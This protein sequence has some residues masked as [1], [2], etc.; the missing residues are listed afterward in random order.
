MLLRLT[1]NNIAS[2]FN[3]A[4]DI[5]VKTSTRGQGQGLASSPRPEPSRPWTDLSRPR[6]DLEAKDKFC[7]RGQGLALRTTSLVDRHLYNYIPGC[8]LDSIEY[9]Q[10][11]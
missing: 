9:W 7:P 11:A 4:V 5:T 8:A 1:S 3:Y 2:L 6:P 10:L